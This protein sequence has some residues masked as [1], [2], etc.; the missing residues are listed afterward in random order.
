MQCVNIIY[1]ISNTIRTKS[2]SVIMRIQQC[3]QVFALNH[4]LG[5]NIFY[6]LHRLGQVNYASLHFLRYNIA[7]IFG[8]I[9]MFTPKLFNHFYQLFFLFSRNIINTKLEFAKYFHNNF[10]SNTVST[11]NFLVIL[12]SPLSLCPLRSNVFIVSFNFIPLNY[13]ITKK[14]ILLLNFVI[15]IQ[16]ILNILLINQLFL[17]LIRF[18]LHHVQPLTLFNYSLHFRILIMFR[19][20]FTN[21]FVSMYIIN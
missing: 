18:L 1:K 12:C 8:F 7:I 20:I 17:L 4:K 13:L 2:D 14:L 11:E 19:N 10:I 3:E 15:Y 21:V 5:F 6:F 9:I 16:L